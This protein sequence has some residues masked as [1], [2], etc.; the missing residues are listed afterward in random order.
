M[1]WHEDGRQ[2]ACRAGLGGSNNAFGFL[3]G[4]GEIFACVHSEQKLVGEQAGVFGGR[5]HG[6]GH[7][8]TYAYTY[9]QDIYT[10]TRSDIVDKLILWHLV[11]S[12]ENV[13]L[14]S[15]LWVRCLNILGQLVRATSKAVMQVGPVVRAVSP[16]YW[17]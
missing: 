10:Y 11:F 15:R 12:C 5:G 6:A 9:I 16:C 4:F 1:A 3:C 17:P 14:M 8:C 13:G 7:A 2:R